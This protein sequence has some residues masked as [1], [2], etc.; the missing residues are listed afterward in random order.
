M[1][2]PVGMGSLLLQGG[3]YGFYQQGEGGAG[4]HF[5]AGWMCRFLEGR[6]ALRVAGE[7][8]I[9]GLERLEGKDVAKSPL[10][11]TASIQLGVGPVLRLAPRL[12][13]TPWLAWNL[14]YGHPIG[15]VLPEGYQGPVHYLIHG[16]DLEFL[17]AF[18]PPAVRGTRRDE[19]MVEPVLGLR[20]LFREVRPLGLEPHEDRRPHLALGGGVEFGLRIGGR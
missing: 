2:P 12:V 15:V 19:V 20:V 3:L 5:K 10:G 17:L 18:A 8:G 4:G 6:L 9:G 16:P 1:G 11:V 7:V 14:G 13:L